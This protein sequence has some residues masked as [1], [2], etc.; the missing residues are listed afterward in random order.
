M[1]YQTDE[2]IGYV[3]ENQEN[4][5]GRNNEVIRTSQPKQ[6]IGLVIGKGQENLIGKVVSLGNKLGAFDVAFG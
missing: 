1:A 3:L 2:L 6:L 4:L 5:V